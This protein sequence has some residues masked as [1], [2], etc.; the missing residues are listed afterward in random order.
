MDRD[1]IMKKNTDA[2]VGIDF[3]VALV[4]LIAVVILAVMIMP[5]MSHE[6]RDWR[7]KQYMTAT[8]ASDNLVQTTGG[9]GW[10][11]VW[12][13]N[14]SNVSTIGLIYVGAEGPK[15]KVLDYNKIKKLMGT[16]YKDNELS[17]WEFPGPS[18]SVSE[19]DNAS[20]A[21]GLSGFNFYMRLHPIGLD[22][23]D[24]NS[25]VIETNLSKQN[26]NFE[27]VSV[28]DRY[29]YIKDASGYLKDR[30]GQYTLHYRLNIWVW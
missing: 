2:M 24:F 1:K 30:Y 9:E 6:D 4:L 15:K 3:I 16:P 8:R 13:T 21:L 10:E 29:V 26:I 7:I 17:W 28:I 14:Y 5:S 27:T 19:Q 23:A 11:N 18:T 25:T 22:I 20:R 12:D